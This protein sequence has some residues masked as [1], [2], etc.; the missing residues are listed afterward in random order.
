VDVCPGNALSI[1]F[2]PKKGRHLERHLESAPPSQ[3]DDVRI[4]VNENSR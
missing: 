2:L 1:P 3:E 4:E